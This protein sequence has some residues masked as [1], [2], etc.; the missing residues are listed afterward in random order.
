MNY[1]LYEFA[2]YS[3]IARDIHFIMVKVL[4]QLNSLSTI[5]SVN[6]FL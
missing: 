1:I 2:M 3:H 4:V 5:K 6:I